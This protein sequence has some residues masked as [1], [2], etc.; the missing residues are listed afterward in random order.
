MI[1]NVFEAFLLFLMLYI[2]IITL[3]SKIRD[4]V[5]YYIDNF[6]YFHSI[7]DINY[8]CNRSTGD[9]RKLDYRNITEDYFL[10]IKVGNSVFYYCKNSTYSDPS[11]CYVEGCEWIGLP[12]IVKNQTSEYHG[13]VYRC[14]K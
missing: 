3:Q 1:E 2:T 5:R 7:V 14:I 9:W 13:I 10:K 4:D 11:N 12:V 6:L 8:L